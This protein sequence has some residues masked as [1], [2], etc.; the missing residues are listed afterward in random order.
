MKKLVIHLISDSSGQAVKYACKSAVAQFDKIETKKYY[1]ALVRNE[2]QLNEILPQIKKAPCMVLYTISNSA[3]R[4]RIRNFCAEAKVPCISV[5]SGIVSEISSFLGIKPK[6]FLESASGLDEDY[7]YKMRA[8]DYTIKHDDG[9][10]EEEW[11]EADLLLVGPSRTSKTPT[12]VY[13]SYNGFKTANIP[14]VPSIGLPETIYNLKNPLV[15][16]FII[17]PFVLREIRENRTEVKVAGLSSEYT[18]INSL[19]EECS[20]LKNLCKTHDWPVIDVTNRSIE[21]TAAKVIKI[22]YESKK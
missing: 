11:E 19:K 21:E 22:Y 6:G 1:W 5:V 9:L 16:A 17:N 4:D 2:E 20:E 7:F 3:L 8:I 10:G 15:I 13:L 18:D 14:Y 12:S